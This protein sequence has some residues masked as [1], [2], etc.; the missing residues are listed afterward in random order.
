MIYE[1]NDYVRYK[2]T[3]TITGDDIPSDITA[4][5]NQTT[6]IGQA[7]FLSRRN[8]VVSE[9][10]W[11]KYI[12]N[13][14]EFM[15]KFENKD[16]KDISYMLSDIMAVTDFWDHTHYKKLY[17]AFSEGLIKAILEWGY[18]KSK[19]V[20]VPFGDLNLNFVFTR[21]VIEATKADI[22]FTT[23][24]DEDDMNFNVTMKLN[25]PECIA[26]DFMRLFS[27]RKYK[28]NYRDVLG[29]SKQIFM[30]RMDPDQDDSIYELTIR[31]S[32][33]NPKTGK[34]RVNFERSEI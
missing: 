16:D 1:K 24:V 4:K 32:L 18:N 9:K 11:M 20:T 17:K 25:S 21:T 28:P 5:L 10:F 19:K 12:Q 30:D 15:R 31:D 2:I 27:N 22:T 6:D 23:K 13:G 29:L 7:I 34:F 33:D 3:F 26:L 14:I 8:I